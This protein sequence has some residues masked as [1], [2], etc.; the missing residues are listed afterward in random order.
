MR[1]L[2]NKNDYA[3]ERTG[4]LVLVSKEPYL[5]FEVFPKAKCR[6]AAATRAPPRGGGCGNKFENTGNTNSSYT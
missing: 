5:R 6:C 3:A 2:S 4:R 1:R